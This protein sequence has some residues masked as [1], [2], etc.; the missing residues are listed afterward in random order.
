MPDKVIAIFLSICGI[1]VLIL[2]A[3]LILMLV[4]QMTPLSC[5]QAAKSMQLD[6]SWS[7][8]GGCFVNAPG[9]GWVPLNDYKYII[10]KE[11]EP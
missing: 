7:F 4:G 9:V 10:I 6:Y 3:G 11:V 2:L 5:E 1:I 8:W